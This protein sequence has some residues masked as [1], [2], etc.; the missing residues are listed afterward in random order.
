LLS[1]IIFKAAAFQIDTPPLLLKIFEKYC[2]YCMSVKYFGFFVPCLQFFGDCCSLSFP[3]MAG[4]V[5]P[6]YHEK[7]LPGYLIIVCLFLETV[8]R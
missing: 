5:L 1:S 4:K 2:L 8:E 3:S 6:P 7:V